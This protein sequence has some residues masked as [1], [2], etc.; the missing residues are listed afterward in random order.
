MMKKSKQFIPQHIA[1]PLERLN[2]LS[3][4]VADLLQVDRDIH[5]LWISIRKNRLLIMTDDSSFATQLRFQQAHI[6][7]YINQ[8]MLMKL[9]Q[10][11]IKV[12]AA[13]P[14][15]YD[16]LRQKCFR[17]SP[18]AANVLSSIAQGIEDEELRTCLKRLGN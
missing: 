4:G 2:E 7:Q 13:P 14:Q 1:E 18:Y 6:E 15:Y 12:I 16:A 3:E 17:I 11:K 5:T 8:K 10:V 9:K